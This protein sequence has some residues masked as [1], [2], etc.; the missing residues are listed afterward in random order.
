[1]NE[2]CRLGCLRAFAVLMLTISGVA[3]AKEHHHES[4]TTL[5]FD[6][7]RGW[8][9]APGHSDFNRRGTAYVDMQTLET[10]YL[11]HLFRANLA[12]V[13]GTEGNELEL[14]AEI[15]WAV[16]RRILFAAELPYT[17]LDPDEGPSAE[18]FADF[19][20]GARF[21]LLEFDRFV[22]ALNAE[23]GFP[24]GRRSVGLSAEEVVIEPSLLAWFDLGADFTLNVQAGYERGVESDETQVLYRAAVAWSIH[25]R[26]SGM[27]AEHHG[28]ETLARHG[29]ELHGSR[30]G[31]LSIRAEF[32]ARTSLDGEAEGVTTGEALVGVTYSPHDRFDLRAGYQFPVMTPREL[33]NGWLFGATLHF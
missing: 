24:T 15:E 9:E 2:S 7:G 10:P 3:S 32:S 26:G 13:N 16:T 14:S 29:H 4:E 1:M 19:G 11:C 6:L 27:A 25:T 22:L 20:M 23:A 17:W 12:A 18:G 8:L 30:A 33:T 28:G 5:G 21:L 31:L